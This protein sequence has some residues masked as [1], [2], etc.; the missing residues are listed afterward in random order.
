[1]LTVTTTLSMV[2]PAGTPATLSI[3]LTPVLLKSGMANERAP[4]LWVTLPVPLDPLAVNKTAGSPKHM[5]AEFGVMIGAVGCGLKTTEVGEDVL[6][7]DV[8][9]SVITTVYA[10]VTV[11]VYVLFVSPPMVTPSF[12]H[13]YDGVIA[14][15]P[16]VSNC[17]VT[18][19]QIFT[20]PDGDSVA[21][22]SG[23]MVIVNILE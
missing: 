13:T 7:Q 12:F 8:A 9:P 18:G 20:V 11:T 6:L 1:M 14:L 21:V 10:P 2:A 15:V 17:E 3:L 22:G 16:E 23:L 5:V 19:G 4:E